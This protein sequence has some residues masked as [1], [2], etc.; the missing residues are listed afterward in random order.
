[1]KSEILYT[2]THF[3]FLNTV[4][5]VEI[6]PCERLPRPMTEP[7][8]RRV[9]ST[10]FA[11]PRM[12]LVSFSF[13][14][15]ANTSRVSYVNSLFLRSETTRTVKKKKSKTVNLFSF[16][17]ILF[18]EC[19]KTEIVKNRLKYFGEKK[20]WFFTGENL[21]GRPGKAVVVARCFWW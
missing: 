18:S 21:Q 10:R 3:F 5:H 19:S 2:H 9:D 15:G 7:S 14:S 4:P 12:L 6:L 16:S 13:Q 8:S 20:F 17:F 1:M 11:S